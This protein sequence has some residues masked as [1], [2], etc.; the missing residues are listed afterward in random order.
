MG[1]ETIRQENVIFSGCFPSDI[2]FIES[3]AAQP[4]P[5]HKAECLNL[6]YKVDVARLQ[7]TCLRF[8][9]DVIVIIKRPSVHDLW[10]TFAVKFTLPPGDICSRHVH[11][12]TKMCIRDS[13]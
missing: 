10:A 3:V 6:K 13:I 12:F 1:I 9:R 7:T 2:V 5:R 8:A 11:W 4:D